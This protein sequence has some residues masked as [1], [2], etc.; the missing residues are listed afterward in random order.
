MTCL[1]QEN[2]YLSC[3]CFVAG[4]RH[5]FLLYGLSF[6]RFAVWPESLC[7]ASALL[8]RAGNFTQ[9]YTFYTL[10]WKLNVSGCKTCR[11]CIADKH[12]RDLGIIKLSTWFENQW[13]F[14]QTVGYDCHA[15]FLIILSSGLRNGRVM[16]SIFCF[17]LYLLS[18]YLRL[19]T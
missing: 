12:C 1:L 4:R 7:R 13:T 14:F 11:K 5:R 10:R 16:N 3:P 8:T 15:F 19:L 9:F 6:I 2:V 17:D 18:E